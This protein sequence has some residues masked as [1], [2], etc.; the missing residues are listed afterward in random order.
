MTLKLVLAVVFALGPLTATAKTLNSSQGDRDQ[1]SVS[2]VA[3]PA[4]AT[5]DTTAH[6]AKARKHLTM[7]PRITSPPPMHDPN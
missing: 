4:A 2:G 1:T 3:G 7:K 5:H 6:R